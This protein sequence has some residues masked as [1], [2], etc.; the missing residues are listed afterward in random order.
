MPKA[1]AYGSKRRRSVEAALHPSCTLRKQAAFVNSD[2][3]LPKWIFVTRSK[4]KL[5][6]FSRCLNK[7]ERGEGSPQR[8][9]GGG[10]AAAPVSPAA[11]QPRQLL[12]ESDGFVQPCKKRAEMRSALCGESGG[13]QGRLRRTSALNLSTTRGEK[14]RSTADA[15]GTCGSYL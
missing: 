15:T 14:G 7:E 9:D 4:D 12:G 3:S 2:A 10:G 13:A 6:E 1:D 11:V 8:E 5:G